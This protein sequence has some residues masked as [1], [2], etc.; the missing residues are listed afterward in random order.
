L[1]LAAEKFR[2]VPEFFPSIVLHLQQ[3]KPGYRRRP[4]LLH[5]AKHYPDVPDASI[6][7]KPI[8]LVQQDG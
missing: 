8:V 1:R 7:P 5:K 6:K 3:I 4:M 2:I